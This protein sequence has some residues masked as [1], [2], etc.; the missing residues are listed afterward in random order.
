MSFQRDKQWSDRWTPLIQQ[1]LAPL[2]LRPSSLK[3]DQTEAA[4][5]C[6]ATENVRIGCR[7]RAQKYAEKYGTQFTIRSSRDTGAKTELEKIV[8][9]WGDWMFYGFEYSP[10]KLSPWFVVDLRAFRA[11]LVRS[12]KIQAKSREQ[13]TNRGDGTSFVAFDLKDFP[14]FPRICVA[15]SEE[16]PTVPWERAA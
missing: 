7:V 5:L 1:L 15:R 14:P 8:D 11:A 4:D 2:L 6:L 9:G 13:I 3:V 12:P 10:T 16:A